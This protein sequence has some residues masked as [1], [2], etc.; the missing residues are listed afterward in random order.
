[1]P[2]PCA[3]FRGEFMNPKDAK[4]GIMTHAFHYGTAT[5]G[6]LN[7]TWD[8]EKEHH[9][10]FRIL[11]H[12]RRQLYAC[13][14]LHIKLPHTAEEMADITVEAVRRT[15]FR[16][17]VY[18]RP[19]AYKSSESLGVRLH[20]LDADWT[21]IATVL[22]PF[23]SKGGLRCATSSWVRICDNQIPTHGK[24]CGGYVNGAL[25]KTEAQL[26]GFDDAI[27]LTPE[28]HV[29]EGAVT[30]TFLVLNGNL[31]TPSPADGIL[32]GMTRD[33]VMKLAQNELGIETIERSIVRSELYR[34][35]EA[36]FTGTYAG[37]V[38]IVEIDLRSVGDGQPGPLT[39]K[40]QTMYR[41]LAKG[42]NPKYSDWYTFVK[43]SQG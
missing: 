36:F 23:S 31:V 19:V 11:D 37:V 2:E 30:N 14:L 5:F 10:I 26:V 12:F 3:Y 16:Q 6:G 33:T 41:E 35:R 9:C 38:P 25:A 22:P 34:A 28:G 4:I 40:L 29:S 32:L 15:G 27:M 43:P 39:T 18:I 17:N 24:V 7:A 13:K 1:M 20:D 8:E 21:V 42:R